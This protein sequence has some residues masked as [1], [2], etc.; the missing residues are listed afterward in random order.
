MYF[1]YAGVYYDVSDTSSCDSYYS[2]V[3]DAI[4]TN[5]GGFQYAL[6]VG[7]GTH[8]YTTTSGL[9]AWEYNVND[10]QNDGGTHLCGVIESNSV[11]DY[12]E[13]NG[14]SAVVAGC[15]GIMIDTTAFDSL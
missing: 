10:C 1:M 15:S 4:S 6:R 12:Y 2:F 9:R 7:D 3:E 5:D 8:Y 14:A 11:S 13:V